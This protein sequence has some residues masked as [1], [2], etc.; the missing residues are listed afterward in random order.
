MHTHLWHLGICVRIRA[1]RLLALNLSLG[2]CFRRQRRGVHL[3]LLPLLLFELFLLFLELGALPVE[4][5]GLRIQL[6]GLHLL[7]RWLWF[8][9]LR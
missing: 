9:D 7:A 2:L 6:T 1:R 5:L 4:F 3:T 8:L